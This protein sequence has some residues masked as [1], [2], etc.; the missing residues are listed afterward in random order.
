MDGSSQTRRLNTGPEQVCT[1]DVDTSLSPAE[2]LFDALP[3]SFWKKLAR[4]SLKYAVSQGAF[5]SD[6]RHCKREWFTDSNYIRVFPS[7]LMRGLVTCRSNVECFRGVTFG[8]YSQTCAE[9]V[10]GISLNK[11]EQL[12]RYLHLVDNNDKK[13]TAD[14]EFDKC[15]TVRPL[16]RQLQKTYARWVQPG[17]NNGVWTWTKRGSRLVLAGYALI[18][19]ASQTS[20]L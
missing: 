15:F 18:I 20:I 9:K 1:F 13:D 17:K 16:I 2:L 11:Y 3:I 6:N 8:K 5:G 10:L 19:R 4:M 12:L 14:D 7:M